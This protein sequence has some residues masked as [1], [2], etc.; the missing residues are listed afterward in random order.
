[1]SKTD[2][3][4]IFGLRLEYSQVAGS[5]LSGLLMVLCEEWIIERNGEYYDFRVEWT[6]LNND[7]SVEDHGV[8]LETNSPLISSV[9]HWLSR[10]RVYER[11]KKLFK[12]Y[13][14]GGDGFKIVDMWW[15]VEGK[16]A[17]TLA[18]VARYLV[19]LKDK[20]YFVEIGKIP[21]VL[22]GVGVIGLGKSLLYYTASEFS[23]FEEELGMETKIPDLDK[24]FGRPRGKSFDVVV[25]DE[26]GSKTKEEIVEKRIGLAKDLASPAGRKRPLYTP[27][28]RV[29]TKEDWE[30]KVAADI[31]KRKAKE[32]TVD[33]YRD[34]YKGSEYETKRK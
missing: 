29:M 8:S 25:L 32:E 7:R 26:A 9:N 20:G 23:R 10:L 16:E 33:K 31:K 11:D 5:S 12:S 13:T 6:E 27:P 14:V 24:A 1:M 21:E 15:H 3:K 2:N 18:P 19:E 22:K 17:A 34:L 28:S 4:N 30:R